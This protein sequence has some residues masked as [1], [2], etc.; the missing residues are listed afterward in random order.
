MLARQDGDV[1]KVLQRRPILALGGVTGGTRSET[2]R[3]D[4]TM[5]Q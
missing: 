3:T 2:I 5:V 4:T 1:F